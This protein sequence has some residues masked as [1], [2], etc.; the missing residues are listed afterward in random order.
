MFYATPLYAGIAAFILMRLSTNVI[1]M[2][3]EKRITVGDGEDRMLLRVMRAQANFI[4]YT[5]LTLLLL[6][7]AEFMGASVWLIH[8]GGI[9][10]IAGR[11]MHMRGASRRA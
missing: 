6:G 1:G 8:L 7:F 10:L 9:A 3:R 2:R 4:E 11:L 5:P